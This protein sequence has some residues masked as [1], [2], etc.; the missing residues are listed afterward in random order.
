M[1][2]ERWKVHICL[3]SIIVAAV[4]I[5]L[6]YYHMAQETQIGTGD[7]LVRIGQRS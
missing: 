7:V 5:G 6:C 4:I 2:N 1:K 3:I